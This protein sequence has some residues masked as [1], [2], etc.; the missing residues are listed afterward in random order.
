MFAMKL[1]S[2]LQ[3][4]EL[5]AETQEIKKNIILKFAIT[6]FKGKTFL[7]QMVERF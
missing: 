4:T 6:S 3:I 1:V 7:F 5:I 2:D